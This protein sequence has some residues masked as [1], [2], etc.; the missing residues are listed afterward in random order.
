MVSIIVIQGAGL[1]ILWVYLLQWMPIRRWYERA[2]R[3]I[4]LIF[5]IILVTL[6]VR[7]LIG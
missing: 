1:W 2:A 6:A 4:D 5:S 3:W 7:L